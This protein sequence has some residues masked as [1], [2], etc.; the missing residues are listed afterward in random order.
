MASATKSWQRGGAQGLRARC[1]EF[2]DQKT[3]GHAQARWSYSAVNAPACLRSL[4]GPKV[5]ITGNVSPTAAISLMSIGN[6]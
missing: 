4:A 1:E 3:R 5:D 2:S 6:G